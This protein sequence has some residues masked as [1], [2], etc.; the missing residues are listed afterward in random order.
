MYVIEPD[1]SLASV[2]DGEGWM[3]YPVIAAKGMVYIS[4][5][6]GAIWAIDGDC[7]EGQSADLRRMADTGAARGVNFGDYAVVVKDRG[8]ITWDYKK[9]YNAVPTSQRFLVT[10]VNRDAYVD[11]VDI[12]LLAEQW[13]QQ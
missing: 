5:S 11:M 7:A 6:A 4:D 13:L 10:D 9:V 8:K 2:F 1:G 3:S 12:A